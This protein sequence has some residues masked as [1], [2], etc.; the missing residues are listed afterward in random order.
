MVVAGRRKLGLWMEKELE[1]EC[2]GEGSR[3]K[4]GGME[5][6]GVSQ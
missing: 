4:V 2:S 1:F 6:T 5:E 3:R